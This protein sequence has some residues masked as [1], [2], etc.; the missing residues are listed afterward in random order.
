MDNYFWF[1]ARKFRTAEP[2][3]TVTDIKKMVNA[4]TGHHFFQERNGLPDLAW[5][6]SEVVD[7]THEPRFWSAPVGTM[8]G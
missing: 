1:G 6:D 5:G 2:S 8:W 3:M 7:L 4:S